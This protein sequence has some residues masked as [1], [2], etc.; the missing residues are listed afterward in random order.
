MKS[1]TQFLLAA[2]TLAAVSA[3]AWS[4]TSDAPTSALRSTT[5]HATTPAQPS[6][7][8]AITPADVQALKEALAAQQ[9]Q[10]QQLSQQLQQAQQNWQ[11]A[12]AAATEATKK[13]TAAQVQA[14]EQQE[15][16]GELKSDV[17]DLKAVSSSSLN[18]SNG[19]LANGAV[20]Q[21]AVLTQQD[22]PQSSSVVAGDVYNKQMESPITIRFKG[23]NIT[24]GGYA[25]A[26]FVRRSRA[27]S[28]DIPTP[29]NSLTM[30]GASQSQIS[31]FF[32]SGRQSK[33]T[34]F[35]DGRLG[36]VDLS[37]YVSADFLSAG[38][39]STATST[40]SYTLRLRQAWAQAKFSNG[41]SFAGGQMW[42]LVT[43]NAQGITVDDDMGK[44]NDV[45]PKTIDPTYNVGFNFARQYG[46]RATKSFGDKVA[47]GVSIENEQATVTTHGNA[48]NF[49]LGNLGASNS[50]NTTATYSF[51]PAPDIVAKIAFDPGFGH[52]EV[53]GLID[54]FTGRVFPCVEFAVGSTLCTGG[55]SATG[56]YN[57]SKEGA[58]LGASA[59]WNIAK[60]VTFGV[61][62]TG[63]SGIGRY[64]AG[65]LPDASINADGTIHLIKNF[66]GLGTLELHLSKKLDIYG[67]GGAE[68]AARSYSFDPLQG[69]TGAI[70]GYGSPTFK[71]YGCYTE[72]A[73]GSGGFAPGAL[74]NC[75]G[76]TRALIEGTAGFWYRFYTGPKGS[77][78]YGT[79]VSY[80][81]RNSWSGDGGLPAGSAGR[82]P[83]GIDTM[84]FT[85]FRYYLP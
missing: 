75:T 84:V 15:T 38:V 42:S 64:A 62:G 33:I 85:S 82:S 27:L 77:F 1:A 13:A 9:L 21:N 79:Q 28:S 26:E 61:K 18:N 67:Y 76:D 44:T 72:I 25:A 78:R 17:A 40:N 60:R 68:Y 63:G 4:Q 47:I 31:E 54:R 41:F 10:I 22:A 52:Y 58:G 71:N 20:L 39:T 45:R 55:T 8:P 43:E 6:T 70:V 16:V 66:Q 46:L 14:T 56:A 49:L 48:N 7:T 3:G 29:F 35:V 53:F 12:Q 23:I 50:Y 65:G 59:R 24:P 37:S 80:V 30:P 19:F 34:T 81:T 51:N 5:K 73:P 57:H 74:A 11:Q 32:G 83:N 2:L 36:N 69:A